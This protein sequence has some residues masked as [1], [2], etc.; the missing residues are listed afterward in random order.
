MK[1]IPILVFLFLS[2]FK[3][4]FAPEN[5]TYYQEFYIPKSEV[6]SE[7][8]E[9]AVKYDDLID[10]IFYHESIRN[11]K[12]YNK[13]ENAVGGLQIRQCRID[14]YNKLTGKSY[15]LDDM[16]DFNKAKEVFLYFTNHDGRGKRIREKSFETAAKNWNGSGPMTETYWASIQNLLNKQIENS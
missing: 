6:I 9:L 1:V 10:A 14:H 13:H 15:T 5:K 2:N 8:P 16:Y 3:L 11:T 4:S 12:A 7:I